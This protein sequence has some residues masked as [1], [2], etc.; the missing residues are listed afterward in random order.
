MR[1][2]RETPA[3]FEAP[4]GT[5]LAGVGLLYLGGP[6]LRR[7]LRP[8]AVCIVKSVLRVGDQLRETAAVCGSELSEI[9]GEGVPPPRTG[10]QQN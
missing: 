1:F 5:L 10:P 8:V 9:A 3:L 4:W 2:W 7:T 6:L